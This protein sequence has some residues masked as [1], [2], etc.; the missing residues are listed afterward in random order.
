MDTTTPRAMITPGYVLPNGATVIAAS[1]R[2][3]HSWIVLAMSG[4]D[5]VTWKCSRP[6]D[7]SDTRWGHYFTDL[8][9]AVTDYYERA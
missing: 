1:T 5:Y 9:E 7:G 8:R 6:G 3:A 2:E 4:D